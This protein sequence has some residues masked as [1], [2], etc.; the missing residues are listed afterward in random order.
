VMGYLVQLKWRLFR[1][2]YGNSH[3][4]RGRL[5]AWHYHWGK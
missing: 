2:M 4:G 5:N 3:F 1:H